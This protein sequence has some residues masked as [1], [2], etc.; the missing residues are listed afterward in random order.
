MRS[1][2]RFP[3]KWDK[4]LAL[5]AVVAAAAAAVKQAQSR[6]KEFK[7]V[8]FTVSQ[9]VAACSYRTVSQLQ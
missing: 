9:Q 1:L 7:V 2:T 6:G 3:S 4:A 5:L 8:Q